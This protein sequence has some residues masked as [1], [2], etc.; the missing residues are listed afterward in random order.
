[1]FS[2]DQQHHPVIVHEQTLHGGP[3]EPT[4]TSARPVTDRGGV[5]ARYLLKVSS[6]DDIIDAI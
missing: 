6:S 5:F 3:D 2:H 4:P 1:M